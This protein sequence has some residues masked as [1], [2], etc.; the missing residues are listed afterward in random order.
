[1]RRCFVTM[2][3]VM[4]LVFSFCVTSSPI[5]AQEKELKLRYS[6]MY[7]P[8]H[9]Y[10]KMMEDWAKEIDTKTQG[11]VKITLYSGGTLTPATQ[12][13]DSTVKGL[14]TLARPCLLTRRDGFLFRKLLPSLWDTT[15]VT[16]PRKPQTPFTRNS[17][18][19]NLPIRKSC[20]FTY[21]RRAS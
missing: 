8:P 18:R 15:A 4:F 17:S 19:K 1:M 9:P 14:Q 10:T 13:Y 3:I 7:P 2:C 20:T 16:R 12:T 5:Q 21:L 11:R 6:N